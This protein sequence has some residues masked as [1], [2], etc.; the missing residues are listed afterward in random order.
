VVDRR[1]GSRDVVVACRHAWAEL[2]SWLAGV[3]WLPDVDATPVSAQGAAEGR[4]AIQLWACSITPLCQ[5]FVH[6]M[7]CASKQAAADARLCHMLLVGAT[8]SA[9]VVDDPELQQPYSPGD[10]K[11]VTRGDV[12]LDVGMYLRRRT[13]SCLT[14]NRKV[15]HGGQSHSHMLW[16]PGVHGAMT[17]AGR[18]GEHMRKQTMGHSAKCHLS[19][20]ICMC[21]ATECYTQ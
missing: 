20:M 2:A 16:Q 18:K 3:L 11:V 7:R 9:M 5:F 12:H 13:L 8:S 19:C 14:V 17:P 6:N 21:R 15:L 10:V 1:N 4:F